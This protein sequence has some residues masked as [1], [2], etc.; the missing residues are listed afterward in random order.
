MRMLINQ[1]DVIL[2]VKQHNNDTHVRVL[3]VCVCIDYPSDGG[4][5]L[6]PCV[7]L[8]RVMSD[9]E[10][11]TVIQS[12]APAGRPQSCSAGWCSCNQLQIFQPQVTAPLVKE[13]LESHTCSPNLRVFTMELLAVGEE[14]VHISDQSIQPG[15]LASLDLAANGLQICWLCHHI[16]VVWI[17]WGERER[18]Q[19]TTE[20]EG[21]SSPLSS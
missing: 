19:L 5:V 15:V 17:L 3:C 9:D 1:N 13:L 4:V 18:N 20:M 6:S 8:K 21:S 2:D 14:E 10:C 11:M 7:R 16:V 12:F